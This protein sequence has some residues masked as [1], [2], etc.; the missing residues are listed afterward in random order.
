MISA[1]QTVW[2]V[3][4][5]IINKPQFVSIDS[6]Q[7]GRVASLVKESTKPPLMG[8]PASDSELI[9]YELMASAVNYRY[10]Y[11][12]GDIRINNSS[13]SKLY[14][15]L[16][17]S[18]ETAHL[19]SLKGLTK[20][21]PGVALNNFICLLKQ[22]RFPAIKE[23]IAHLQ[24]LFDDSSDHLYT[25]VKD[26]FHYHLLSRIKNNATVEECLELLLENFNGFAED[27]FLKRACLFFMQLHRRMGWFTDIGILPV[28]ADYQVPKML[29]YLG[30]LKYVS[31]LE[32]NI[33][34]SR[35]IPEGSVQECEIRA[36]TIIACRQIAE[37]SGKTMC[38]VDDFLWSRR[39]ECNAPFH[40][41]ITTNY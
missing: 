24:E 8:Y 22:N 37:K 23:R 15:L 34:D 38:D 16:T 6:K 32:E 35:L 28:P 5:N 13:A 14:T 2:D 25:K 4:E 1:L 7:V 3:A 40:L 31:E 36:S 21:T 17:T 29:R 20:F 30:V 26:N 33:N 11:G 10:W 39:K 27:I 9:L 12:R 18:F 19:P 41:T